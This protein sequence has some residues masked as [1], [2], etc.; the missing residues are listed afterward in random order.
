MLSAVVASL[1]VLCL[2][3]GIQAGKRFQD[4]MDFGRG[5]ASKTHSNHIDGWSPDSNSWNEKLYPAW[6]SGDARWENCWRG[7]K[8]VALLTSDSPALIGSNVTFAVNLQFPRCQKEN[9]DGDIVY[10]R[11]CGNVS[12]SSPDQYVYNWTKWIDF[13][14]EGNCSFANNFPDG[15]PFPHPPHWRRHNFIYIFSTQGQYFQKIGRSSAVLSINTTNITAGTQVIEVTVFRKGYRKHYPVAKASSIYVVTDQIPFYVNLS[16]TNDKNSSDNIFIKDSPIKFDIRIHDP[17]RYLNTSKLTFDWDYGDGSGSFVSNNP[18]SSHTYTLLGN[19][20][21]NLTI[22]AAI[23]GPCKPVTLTPVPTTTTTTSTTTSS[24]ITTSNSTGNTTELPPLTTGTFPFTTEM[25]NVTTG[26]TTAPYTTPSYTTPSPGCFIYRY[27]YYH[28]KITVV[29]G[30]LAVSIVEMTSVQVS[31]SQTGNSL[32][33]FVVACQGSLPTDACTIVSD[34]SCMTAKDMVCDAVPSSDQCLLT[35]R[36][37]F[38]P[39]SYCVNITLSDG[40]SLALASTLVSIDGGPKTQKTISAVLIP[41]ALVALVAVLVGI[42]L[43]KKYKQYKPITNASDE[44]N[45]QG[46]T[47]H[48]SQIKD[49]FFKRNTEQD[50]LLKSKAAII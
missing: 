50:P 28:T 27:G 14:N 8:V 46:F 39:G 5:S 49:V 47:V 22:K 30:I 18:I 16:Q 33:D 44:R 11:G 9:E 24:A 25:P 23:P 38:E 42:A 45:G 7:G 19:F 36:R 43:Y 48:F 4:V 31:T 13:C 6:K 32:I 12:S 21:V 17:S 40:A 35:L 26:Y 10:Q 20:S 3:S 34:A 1:L 15:K 37:A 2:V 29:D 41:L